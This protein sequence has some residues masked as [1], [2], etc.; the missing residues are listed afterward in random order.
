MSSRVRVMVTYLLLAADVFA[1]IASYVMAAL[2]RFGSFRRMEDKSTYFGACAVLVMAC[3]IYVLAADPY[4]DFLE[5]G[6][7][8]EIYHVLRY[9]VIVSISGLVVLYALHT[10]D[11]I[12]RLVMGY[13]FLI[14]LGLTLGSHL[15]IRRGLRA[16]WR[17]GDKTTRVLVISERAA[18]ED[19]IHRLHNSLDLTRRM[20][21]AVC[22]DED[23]TGTEIEEIPVISSRAQL[24]EKTTQMPL[25][26]VFIYTPDIAQANLT[27]IIRAFNDMGVTVHFSLEI[28]RLFAGSTQVGMFAGYSVVS[29]THVT[30][31]HRGLVI[32]RATDILGGLVGLLITGILL[33][34]V[35]LAIR[36]DS[37]GP[38]FFSQ[39]RIGRNGRRFRIYKF[40]TMVAD[41]ER[42]KKQLESQN[43]MQG[44]IFKMRNDPRITK[45][46]AFLRKTSID[47]FPQFFNILRGDMSLVGTRPPT[48]SEFERYDQHYRRRLSMTPGLTGLWQVS[49]RSTV[50][51]FEDILRYDLEYIDHWSLKMDLWILCKTVGVVFFGRGAQ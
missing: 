45:V 3:L 11:T 38:V 8:L 48:E 1:V 21:G 26:E 24:V 10:V 14:D 22:L 29:Y 50:E 46:G 28:E 43:E 20:V 42:Q 33:P 16:Y 4:R 5:R 51:N 32:K 7:I 41:A 23:M 13:W 31:R 44:P 39:I 25:D 18:I 19:C 37:P 47:E 27:E 6:I 30:G 35:A 2:I 49:G 17:S 15:L 9:E 36:L 40:R 34:F 12:S